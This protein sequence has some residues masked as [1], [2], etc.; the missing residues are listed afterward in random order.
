MTTLPPVAEARAPGPDPGLIPDREDDRRGRVA[1]AWAALAGYGGPL[2]EPRVRRA[3]AAARAYAD[4]KATAADLVAALAE[5]ARAAAEAGGR[6]VGSIWT[7][8]DARRVASACEEHRAARAVADALG[9]ALDP[10]GCLSPP[11]TRWDRTW[12]TADVTALARGI[13][14][15]GQYELLPVLADAL[16]DAGCDDPVVLAH[17][18]GPGPH[19]PECWAVAA[20][21]GGGR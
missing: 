4:R 17:C 11:D 20:A 14:H 13:D 2:A 3:L 6:S 19:G 12:N 15:A 18:R 21:L 10:A 9:R 5:L 1:L 8:A 16:E 7:V